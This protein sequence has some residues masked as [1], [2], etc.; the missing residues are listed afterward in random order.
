MSIETLPSHPVR[1]ALY[2]SK[3]FRA[4]ALG[5]IL[6]VFISASLTRA[7]LYLI[8]IITDSAISFSEGG[9]SIDTVW[10]W[11]L[12]FPIVYLITESTWRCSGFCGMRWITGAAAEA[13]RLLFEYLSGHSA[14]YFNDRY[15]GALTNKISNASKGVEQLIGQTLWQF[16]SLTIGLVGDIY[17]LSLSHY[18]LGLILAGWCIIY[19]FANLLFVSKLHPLAFKNAESASTLKG[20]LV[21]STANIET[22][23]YSGDTQYE[24]SYIGEFITAW[25]GAHLREWWSSEW[26]LIANGVLLGFFILAMLSCS[27]ILLQKDLISV[28]ALAMTITLSLSLEHRFWFLG[29][30]MTHTVSFYGQIKE[31]LAELLEPHAIT[32][33]PTAQALSNCRGGI[34]FKDLSFSY[35]DQVVFSALNLE[36]KAGEKVG[37]VG[38]SGAG[39][40]TLVNLLLRQFDPSAGKILIDG[41]AVDDL[42]LSSLRRAIAVVPQSTSLFHRT[43]I[44]NIRYGRLSASDEEV[45]AAAKVAKADQFIQELSKGYGTFVGERGVKLS[46]GQRQRIAIARAIL[47]QAPIL[48]LDEATSSLDS[49]SEAAIQQ[50]IIP[51]MKDKTVLAIAHRL[52]TLKVMDRIVVM[53]QGQIVEQGSHQQLLERNGIYARHWKNQVSGFIQTDTV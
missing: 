16:Y 12:S 11:T 36:I 31:G 25:R 46:G 28:G 44:D 50:A 42:T 35:R 38:A 1:F 26:V 8:R 29:Q 2:C 51:L 43:I 21:D 48:V 49:E 10:F 40:S 27:V 39:K 13:Y 32:D 18:S 30:Q 24:K 3:P 14:A 15:A 33:K 22:V 6:A 52:S 34:V 4:W 53:E 17:L 19:I 23:Q 47:K 45:F 9:A 20:K 41:V 5:A 7:M 37:L